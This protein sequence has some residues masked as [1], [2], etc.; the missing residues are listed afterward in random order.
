MGPA[1]RWI[2]VRII[3]N[4]YGARAG[5]ARGRTGGREAHDYYAWR[6]GGDFVDRF[7]AAGSGRSHSGARERVLPESEIDNTAS[8]QIWSDEHV[9]RPA[10]RRRNLQTYSGKNAAGV[11]RESRIAHD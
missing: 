2:H 4:A 3:W 11:V 10:D 9:L 7:C 8:F 6:P 5:G 1:S